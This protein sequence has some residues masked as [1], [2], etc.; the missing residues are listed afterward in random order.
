M[1]VI[2]TYLNRSTP[3]RYR[4]N[5][6]LGCV[7]EGVSMGDWIW[8]LSRLSGKDLSSMGLDIIQSSGT[9]IEQKQMRSEQNSD[10]WNWKCS[11][12]CL[13]HQSSSLSSLRTAGLNTSK[14]L[15]LSPSASVWEL[16][17]LFPNSWGFQS[18][19]LQLADCLSWG[20]SV[21]IIMPVNSPNKYF[22]IY[23][24]VHILFAQSLWIPD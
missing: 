5:I 24:S 10:S 3:I 2:L 15:A 9:W 22:L 11:F 19:G 6:I 21:F 14:L 7:H 18:Q 12:Y 17:H 1:L 13:E 4:E 23:L 8:I 20:F 16:Q